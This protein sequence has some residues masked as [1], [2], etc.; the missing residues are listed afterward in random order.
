MDNKKCKQALDPV[1][2]CNSFLK[3]PVI[4][5]QLLLGVKQALEC[6]LILLSNTS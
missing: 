5:Y 1:G 2:I 4:H 6:E 3:T